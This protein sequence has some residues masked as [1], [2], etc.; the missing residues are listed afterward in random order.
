MAAQI[1]DDSP[2]Y[3]AKLRLAEQAGDELMIRA[4]RMELPDDQRPLLD[5]SDDDLE[6]MATWDPEAGIIER[7]PGGITIRQGKARSTAKRRLKGEPEPESIDDALERDRAPKPTPAPPKARAPRRA[8]TPPKLSRARASLGSA[9]GQGV[10]LAGV[11]LQ[12]SGRDI[13]VG[14]ALMFEGPIAGEKLDLLIAGTW[15]DNLLQPI[16]RAGGAAK[17]LGS[18]LALPVLVGLIERR[19]NL[20][21][22]LQPLLASLVTD[23]AVQLAQSEA[24][25]Q[26]RIKEAAKVNPAIQRRAEELMNSLMESMFGPP[27]EAPSGAPEPAAGG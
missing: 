12:M 15:I 3:K 20:F 22:I 11:G 23:L 8:P 27:P 25:A 18:V 2:E 16:V 13:P 14:R 24:A 19:P 6:E 9:L 21:P 4:G 7:L 5:A 10:T 17:D 26:Q 1:Q